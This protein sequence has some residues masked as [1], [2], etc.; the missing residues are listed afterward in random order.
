[1]ANGVSF[2]P[3]VQSLAPGVACP[4][5]AQVSIR[6][7]IGLAL[8]RD[9]LGR[10][11]ALPLEELAQEV[12]GRTTVPLGLDQAEAEKIAPYRLPGEKPTP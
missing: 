12:A 6:S 10:G 8:L 11:N 2:G 4:V 7:A 1:M 3:V 9:P 5:Q